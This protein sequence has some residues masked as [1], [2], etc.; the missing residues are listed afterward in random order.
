MG[1]SFKD[2]G[3]TSVVE[4]VNS[5]LKSI[6]GHVQM[7]EQFMKNAKPAAIKALKEKNWEGFA[8]AYNGGNWRNQNPEYA[9]DM[10]SH[11]E[12]YK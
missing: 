6:D 12:E 4:M 2:C 8:T 9:N 3:C 7:F 1:E 5:Y 10:K 11:Y